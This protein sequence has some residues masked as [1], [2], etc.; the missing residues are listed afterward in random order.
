VTVHECRLVVE[1]AG[2]LPSSPRFAC[3]LQLVV[4]VPGDRIAVLCD[5]L[6]SESEVMAFVIVYGT[7]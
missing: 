3:A 5:V 6:R 7:G 1:E 2:R 4:D